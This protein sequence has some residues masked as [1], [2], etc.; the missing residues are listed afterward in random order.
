MISQIKHLEEIVY[1]KKI[2]LAFERELI[3]AESNET[4]WDIASHF[5]GANPISLASD[6][7]HPERIYCGTFD[8][9]L[10]RSIDGGSSWEPIGTLYTFS[11]VY[12]SDVVNMK[13]ITAVSVSPLQ[14]LDGNGIIYVG[15]E[16]S[17]LF[18][19]ENGGDSFELLTDYRQIPSYSSWF[20][21]Q[22]TYTHHVKHIEVDA[23]HSH[24]IYTTMEVGGLIKSV[25]Q[26][27]TWEE[28]KVGNY[29]QDIHILK[30]HRHA[31]ERLY[32]VLG[33]SFLKEP[34]HE[35][36][37]SYDGGQTWS[38]MTEGLNH[39][40]AYHMAVNPGDA[41]NVLISTSSNPHA[42]H[43]YENGQCESYIYR[44]EKN[45]K[46]QEVTSGLPTSKGTIIPVLK[47][48]KGGEFYL[49]S[50]KGVFYSSDKGKSWK[51]LD[52]PWNHHLITQ[53]P[54]DM[55]ILS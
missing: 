9:G 40:Y 6:P 30:T 41:D 10:W 32:G 55:L 26:G 24:T 52:I 42:A 37:E 43:M 36:V 44:K 35:Y 22:R 29:P 3:I 21:P 12:Q 39:H 51:S 20:F 45:S 31:P 49:F 53:H 4:G 18:M 2:I 11:D 16:P 17:A 7:H 25:D 28:N 14:G 38:Y 15:T 19:S 23:V 48:G 5:K 33:D 13:S 47:A 1:M 27:N 34:G 50:N 8:R 46:W 54:Y